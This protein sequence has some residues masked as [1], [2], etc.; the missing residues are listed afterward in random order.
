M[1]ANKIIM[2]LAGAAALA[3]GA[4]F[5][6][7]PGADALAQAPV[8]TSA[9]APAAPAP[10][11]PAKSAQVA[12]G[13]YL[14]RLGD[15]I[16][17]HTAAGGKP[18]AGGYALQTPF[19]KLV[20]SNITPDKETGIGG[21]TQEE[22]NRAVRKGVGKH[23]EYLYSAMPYPAYSKVTDQDMVDMKAY[24]D[25]VA[26]VN[27]HVV[28]NQLPFPFNIRFMMFGWNLLFFHD[29][30]FKNDDKQSVEWNRGAY[31]VDGL[32]HCAACHSAKNFLGGDKAALQ[33]GE[34]QG[35]WAPEITSNAY[36][37]L[38][39]WSVADLTAY[40]K[41]GGNVHSVASG[42]MAEAVT[43]STQ[44]FNDADLNAVAVYL[45][46]FPGSD[47]KAG[48]PV[49]SS[50]AAMVHGQTLFLANC[51]ACHS[52]A[53]TG[54]EG[55]VSSLANSAGVRA[56]SP[57]NLLQAVLIGSR[58]A[59][60]QSNP[61]GAAMPNFSWKLSD[62]EIADIA[63]YVRNSWGNASSTVSGGDVAKVRKNLEAQAALEMPAAK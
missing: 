24:L 30:P 49:A 63:T 5:M 36:T 10:A 50:D 38:G 17:C 31:L 22:F 37:G 35:W 7:T 27:N 43:N 41:T 46:S 20:A 19:G 34:L 51:A 33:G 29:A 1:R 15:C 60:T 40:L 13:L 26:P 2:A 4:F 12:R 52:S 62:G 54:V 9:A 42:P 25:T 11:D 28:S 6:V 56:P 59:V 32:G 44:Y 8:A 39:S 45:K 55:M 14:T 61:T 57:A 23:G 58:G 21:W 18:F 16:A 48:T 47:N 53:G 3:A